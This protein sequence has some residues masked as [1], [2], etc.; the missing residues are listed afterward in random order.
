MDVDNAM[1]TINGLAL[2]RGEVMTLRV[3][4]TSFDTDCGDD[5]HG[6]AMTKAYNM[7]RA[8]LLGLLL[9]TRD[10]AETEGQR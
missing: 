3:A 1:V 2:T 7:H 6:K 5:E 4:L 8:M 10:A 9:G